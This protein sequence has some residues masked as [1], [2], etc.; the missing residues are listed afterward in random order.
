MRID[1]REKRRNPKWRKWEKAISR[2]KGSTKKWVSCLMQ[3]CFD[4]T[5]CNLGLS[6]ADFS[7]RIRYESF[8]VGESDA[9][10]HYP[11]ASCWSEYFL[12]FYF[13][14]SMLCNIRNL[15][16]PL[17]GDSGKDLKAWILELIDN[18]QKSRFVLC[19]ELI[20]LHKKQN[21]RA[22]F[23]NTMA[24]SNEIKS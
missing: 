17:P 18:A 13:F 2:W 6:V 19:A 4:L 10:C 16:C 23:I 8:F 20:D 11:L 9:N 22:G 7:K 21:F 5:Y 14:I 3:F 15:K 24:Y 12:F 1:T